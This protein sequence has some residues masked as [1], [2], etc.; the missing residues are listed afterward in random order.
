MASALSL[1]FQTAIRSLSNP[2]GSLSLLPVPRLCD[3][4]RIRFFSKIFA[5]RNGDRDMNSWSRQREQTR[6]WGLGDDENR[7]SWHRGR[8]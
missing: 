1:V 7:W 6:N 4:A 5:D 8:L 2:F 3:N